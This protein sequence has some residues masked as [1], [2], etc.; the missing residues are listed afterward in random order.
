[1][2]VVPFGLDLFGYNGIRWAAFQFAK[3][4]AGQFAKKSK[5]LILRDSWVK[6]LSQGITN[7]SLI[8]EVL[9]VIYM[10]A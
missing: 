2:D 7:E 9:M 4:L 3:Q 8:S 10:Y 5:L 6:L 1:M